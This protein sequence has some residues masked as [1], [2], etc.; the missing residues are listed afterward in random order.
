MS[1]RHL[2]ATGGQPRS[3]RCPAASRRARSESTLPVCAADSPARPVRASATSYP[4]YRNAVAIA[5]T[6]DGS[7]STTNTFTP[8][9]KPSGYRELHPER[10]AHSSL[11]AGIRAS[12]EPRST[13]RKAQ[14]TLL[15]CAAMDTLFGLPAHPLLVHIPIVLLPLAAIGVIVMLIKPEWHRRYRWVVLAM[16]VVGALGCDTRRAGR[17]GAREP[18][19]RCRRTPGSQ[20]LASPCGPR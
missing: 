4:S 5:S 7:S 8:P 18:S 12:W 19:R 9:V 20:P 11:T 17:R 15:A 16:G 13:T 2:R 1:P 6:I 3:R 10:P 14:R